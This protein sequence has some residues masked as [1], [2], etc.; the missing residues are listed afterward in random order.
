MHPKSSGSWIFPS[1]VAL[2]KCS[3][4]L[5]DQRQKTSFLC[6][7]VDV[8]VVVANTERL[9]SDCEKEPIKIIEATHIG[10]LN[11]QSESVVDNARLGHIFP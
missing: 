11:K 9:R 6:S 8:M 7:R 4:C 5:K 10:R 1:Q 2:A 3:F